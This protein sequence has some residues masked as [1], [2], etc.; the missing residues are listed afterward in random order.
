M[1]SIFSGKAGRLAGMYAADTLD[2]AKAEGYGLLDKAQQ[3]ATD[4]YGRAQDRYTPLADLAGQGMGLYADAMGLNGQDGNARAT[5]AFQAG[6][7]YQFALDQGTQAA[8]RGAAGS[9]QLASGNTLMALNRYGQGLANQEYGTWLNGLNGYNAMGQNVVGGQA[10]LDT[11]LAGVG[12]DVANNKAT[13]GAN[14]AQGIASAGSGALM[15][16]QQA[17]GNRMSFGLNL[18]S[19]LGSFAKGFM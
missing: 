9:G 13:I 5:G 19:G 12:L 11:G 14:A 4:L 8:L 3:G 7:G 17:A 10:A 15:A 18:L 2:K 16:G 1:A 6:P